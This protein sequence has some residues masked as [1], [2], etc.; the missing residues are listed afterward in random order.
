MITKK[1]STCH[2]TK[3]VSEFHTRSDSNDR[4]RGQCYPCQ[5]KVNA[6]WRERN[7]D[8]VRGA[9]CRKRERLN[10]SRELR[11]AQRAR[12][13]EW[14]NRAR[15]NPEHVACEQE[16]KRQRRL[17]PEFRDRERE[18]D[19]A[20][21]R[22]R[23]E[24]SKYREYMRVYLRGWRKR[25]IAKCI[26]YRSKRYRRAG[27]HSTALERVEIYERDGGRCH[28]CKRSV[29]KKRF[30]LDHLIPVSMGGRNE[31]NNL[32]LAH[33]RCNRT[34]HVRGPAQLRLPVLEVVGE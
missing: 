30:E 17:D 26:G 12:S 10:G 21:A 32:A 24:D 29:S 9:N 2:E 8:K 33:V 16:R 11:D 27:T 18:K 1:C 25:N 6:Q 7:P 20:Y 22:R 34:R 19:R 13:R 23:R 14:H 15:E 31:R 28:L 3:E 4:L 5:R